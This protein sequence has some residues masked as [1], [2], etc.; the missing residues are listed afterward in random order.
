MDISAISS[1]GGNSISAISSISGNQISALSGL[2]EMGLANTITPIF[3]S[4]T[5]VVEETN[6]GAAFSDI[7]TSAVEN[8]RTTDAEKNQMEYL[9]A[10]GQLDNPA[11]LTIATTKAQTAIELLTQLRTRSLDAY[12]E[13]IKMSI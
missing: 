3:D 5:T 1:L 2:S 6:G 13:I 7:L 4:N 10:V 11:E 12:N 8:V 9:L